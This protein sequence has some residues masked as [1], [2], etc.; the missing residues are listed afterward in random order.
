MTHATATRADRAPI[1]I[2][3]AAL[4]VVAAVLA[5]LAVGA[6]V[7]SL[8]E[9]TAGI[10]GDDPIAAPIIWQLRLPRTVVGLIVGAALGAAGVLAQSVTRNPLADPGLLGISSGAAVSI[11]VGT[12]FFGV[13]GGAG[14]IA[15]AILGAA[16]ATIAV[17]AFA[18]RSP[19]GL[20]PVSMTLAG[21]ALTAFLGAIVSGITLLHAD[22]MDQY[23][24]W[25][26]GSLTALDVATLPAVLVL[27]LAGG[28]VAFAVSGSLNALALGD[29]TASALG[30]KVQRTRLAAGAAVVLLSGV[31][32]SL[33]G[34][35]GF[36]GLIVPHAAR[37]LVG[38]DVR[39]ALAMSAVLGPL[40]L[41]TADVVGRVVVRPSE[42]QVGVV[43]AIVGT[44]VFILL[45]R[46]TRI[47]GRRS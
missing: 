32:V 13:G 3:G 43:T 10:A 31:A 28:V 40:L 35:I 19:E 5:S 16:I 11:V 14:R 20:T 9:L 7:L 41:V 22:S 30:V 27:V 18:N 6:R 17:F 12:A 23:R 42:L 39:R 1:A 34:P 2:A 45:T 37:L 25:V 15:L 26:V 8:E 46:R 47:A 4:L 24:F 44:P 38:G 29:D 21:M 36:V 33:S